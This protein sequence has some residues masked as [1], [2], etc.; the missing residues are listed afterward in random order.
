MSSSFSWNSGIA[1]E[2]EGPH[3]MRLQSVGVPD[4]AH[5]G[6]A[7]ARRRA[8]VRVD[9][10]V[11]FA[12]LLCSVMS[13]TRFTRRSVMVGV[14]ARPRR[15][16]FQSR[17]AACEKA[18]PP[19]RRLLRRHVHPPGNLLVLQPVCGQQHDPRPLH[20]PGGQRTSSRH[21]L[22][23]LSLFRAQ[24]NCGSDA[25]T[26]S[27]SIVWTHLEDTRYYLRRTTLEARYLFSSP[28]K[29]SAAF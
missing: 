6:L 7:D 28:S 15:V 8:M 22:Q 24:V 11:A 16:L 27:S 29:S 12:G 23:G 20:N 18:V 5:A 13:T 14:L 17:D 25:H 3:Q 4:A 1:A 9:Q 10:C 19:A 2:L 21:P 26:M